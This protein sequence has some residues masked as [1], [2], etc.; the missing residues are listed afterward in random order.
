MGNKCVLSHT[1][2]EL[3]QVRGDTGWCHLSPA[4]APLAFADLS[5]C[6]FAL[7]HHN[8]EQSGFAELDESF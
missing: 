5:L 7:V 3:G 8:N 6:P 1:A 2:A 4:Q